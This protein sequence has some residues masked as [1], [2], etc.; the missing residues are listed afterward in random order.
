[1]VDV[2]WNPRLH[3]PHRKW[4]YQDHHYRHRHR[5]ASYFSLLSWVSWK[6]VR[7]GHFYNQKRPFLLPV[8]F[9]YKQVKQSLC[10]SNNEQCRY[11]LWGEPGTKC[12]QLTESLSRTVHV[13][14]CR[15]TWTCF[16]GTLQVM[17]MIMNT[18]VYITKLQI[19]GK[20]KLTQTNKPVR[21]HL[22]D[23]LT[24]ALLS[25]GFTE[26]VQWMLNL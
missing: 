6:S 26:N 19:C 11:V 21:T 15:E 18:V 14:T 4:S 2:D 8:L 1:M 12:F 13:K 25:P 16:Y 7:A 10:P 20:Y 9:I 24:R 23:W 5:F 22:L 17:D 3:V